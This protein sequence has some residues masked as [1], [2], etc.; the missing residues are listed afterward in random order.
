M[1]SEEDAAADEKPALSVASGDER[2]AEKMAK[3]KAARDKIMAS[4]LKDVTAL[5]PPRDPLILAAIVEDGTE[6]HEAAQAEG[7]LRSQWLHRHAASALA[8]RY[9]HRHEPGHS[10]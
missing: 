3:K 1:T 2:H 6:S 7:C 4:K 5:A 9:V 10:R 8:S